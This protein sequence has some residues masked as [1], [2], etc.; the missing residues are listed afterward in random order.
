M[1]NQAYVHIWHRDANNDMQFDTY[2]GPNKAHV[3]GISIHDA[4]HITQST[5]AVGGSSDDGGCFTVTTL[6]IHTEK[7]V[8]SVDVFNTGE[9]DV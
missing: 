5:R 4:T 1:E 9:K 2:G 7:G 3:K 6:V 8:L